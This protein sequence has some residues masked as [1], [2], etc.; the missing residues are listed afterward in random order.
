MSQNPQNI[1]SPTDLKY[2][3]KFR[4]VRTEALKQFKIATDTGNRLKIETTDK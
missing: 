4:S 3:N 2:Y 1:I